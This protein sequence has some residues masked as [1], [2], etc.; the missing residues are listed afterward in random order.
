[1]VTVRPWF[2]VFGFWSVLYYQL[3]PPRNITIMRKQ[4]GTP[5]FL[6]FPHH[7]SWVKNGIIAS[8]QGPDLRRFWRRTCEVPIAP[9]KNVR[10]NN[11][12]VTSVFF[13]KSSKKNLPKS[14]EVL[15]DR[16]SSDEILRKFFENSLLADLRKLYEILTKN[17]RRRTWRNSSIIFVNRA[18]Q[19]TFTC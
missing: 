10:E 15:I 12:K 2:C 16:K 18:P 8:V 7:R 14:Y 9:A 1:M 11:E 3:L 6:M 17:L 19:T 4:S 5:K 13:T